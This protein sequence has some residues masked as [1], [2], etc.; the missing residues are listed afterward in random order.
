MEGSS[1]A[2]R[3]KDDAA[4]EPCDPVASSTSEG[5]Q[6]LP[7]CRRWLLFA[8]GQRSQGQSEVRVAASERLREFDASIGCEPQRFRPFCLPPNQAWNRSRIVWLELPAHR[9]QQ[10]DLPGTHDRNQ[11][12]RASVALF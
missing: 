2:C 4:T 10:N 8:G 11:C 3:Q 7:E 5:M 1:L 6:R 9:R 12:A